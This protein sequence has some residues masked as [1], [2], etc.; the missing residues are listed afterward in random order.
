MRLSWSTY[1]WLG[2]WGGKVEV[3]TAVNFLFGALCPPPYSNLAKYLP[4]SLTP[5][6]VRGPGAQ[7]CSGGE[8]SLA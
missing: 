6:E 1:H 5:S 3:V 4:V 8:A 7:E 2:S